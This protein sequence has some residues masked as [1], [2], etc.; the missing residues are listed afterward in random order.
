MILIFLIPPLVVSLLDL[1]FISR[2]L[3]TPKLMDACGPEDGRP[4]NPFSYME[5]VLNTCGV[6]VCTVR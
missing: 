1:I 2:L 5:Y 6:S 4:N 3:P